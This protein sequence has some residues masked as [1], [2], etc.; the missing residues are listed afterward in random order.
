MT[1]FLFERQQLPDGSMPR[2]SL[3]NGKPA[4]DS[5]NTQ[6]D[7]CAYPLIMAL[8]VGLTDDALLQGAHRAGRQLRRRPRPGVRPRALGGAGRLLTLDD[9]GRDRGPRR[10]GDHRRSQRRPRLGARVARR[11]R[12]VPAQPQE[13]DADH[14]RAA[15]R[16]P[17]LHPPLEDRRSQ[18]RDHLQRR[19]RRPDARP[20]HG[21]RR[22][23]PR[24]RAARAADGQRRRHRRARCRSSTRRS[25][26][27]TASGDGF[28][29]YNG[30]GYG[31]GA[32]PTATRGRRRTRARATCGRCSPASAASTSSTGARSAPPSGAW[33]RC[34]TM[35][36]G[37]GLIPEQAWDLPDLAALAVRD[38]SDDRPRSASANGKPAGSAAALTWSAGQFVRLIARRRRPA[39]CSTARPTPSTATS[40]HAGH[41]DAHRHGAGRPVRRSSTRRRRSPAPRRPA[42]P[43]PWRPPT[44]T[45][46]RD[47]DRTRRRR[48][49]ER[50]VQRQRPAHRRHVGAQ[51]GRHRARR[52]ARRAPCA[53]SSSTSRRARSLRRR[54]PRRRRQRAGQLRLSDRGD[55]KPG[56][57]DLQRFQVFDAGDGHRLPR[58]TRD[59]TPTF[60]SPLGAQLVDVYVH[61][62]GARHDLDGGRRSRSATT[63]SPPAARGA[64]LIEVQG[65]GQ[66]YVD[67]SGATLGHGHH[68]RATRSRASSRSACRRRPRHAA[69][70][71]GLHG[72]P[73]RPG[74]LQPRPG[75]RLPADAAGLPVRRLRGRERR[76]A[77]H[78]RP[79]H[80]AQGDG[81]AHPRGRRQSDE[82][83]YT[84]AQPGDDRAGGDADSPGGARV[85]G[86]PARGAR[87]PA[88]ARGQQRP[89]LVQG[90]PAALRRAARG[91]GAG[92]G[93]GPRR[94]RRAHLFRP[95]NDTRFHPGP[96]IKEQLGLAVGYEGA[97][98]FYVE[99]SLDGL[100]VAAGLHHPAPD[101]LE[102]IRA[103]S[104]PGARP[105]R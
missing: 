15:Q 45:R 50:R 69:A 7:E 35:S 19:Q 4:P 5:F 1:R 49:A 2:N 64:R 22:R 27:R 21:H 65:F 51:H 78:G 95:W 39:R 76:P 9:L 89:R 85:Q 82:L 31:D 44:P 68:Q 93:R 102:R 66:Q 91:A 26:A 79:E 48:G 38:R 63:R 28:L 36:S 81:R 37:V 101:Q 100:L 41:D 56:A 104:T 52:A 96:P 97:G 74:R 42:T 75:A 20:A 60:G 86:L 43:S 34:A 90:E 88:R 55:F 14:Q 47:D 71:L 59:L 40:P 99:L 30:D 72:R 77:L 46:L 11:R 12:R 13:V 83:D 70:G 67:A 94:L 103:R 10:G 58:P 33:T 84:R 73:H 87:V 54:R 29:R 16:R 92:A 3:A 80:G 23:L 17:V 6:L 105:R 61:V 18:R 98:G 57:Y 32:R 8:A 24:V 25:S 62:P 53:P